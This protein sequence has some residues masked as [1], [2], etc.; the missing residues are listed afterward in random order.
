MTTAVV[1]IKLSSVP[2]MLFHNE[3]EERLLVCCL[4][5]II[6]VGELYIV[7][8]RNLNRVLFAL[9]NLLQDGI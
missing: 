1:F 2:A 9:N 6:I 5:S 4:I 3:S 7:E 8:Y